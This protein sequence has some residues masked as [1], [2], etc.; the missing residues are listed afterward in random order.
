MPALAAAARSSQSPLKNARSP[1]A[2]PTL[3]PLMFL[4]MW[5][6]ASLTL[7]KPCLTASAIAALCS[8]REVL[9]F[10]F[11]ARADADA[12]EL[13]AQRLLLGDL[14]RELQQEV[15]I[16]DEIG[17]ERV[18]ADE[19]R[20][21]DGRRRRR[22]RLV[23]ERRKRLDLVPGLDLLDV[24]DVLGVE[25]LGAVDDEAELRLGA[26]HLGDPGRLVA[27]PARSRDHVAA[28]A[29]A[30]RTAADVPVVERVHVG[31]HDGVIAASCRSR[32]RIARWAPPAGRPAP[33]STGCR[34]SA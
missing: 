15:E 2:A 17:L 18:L 4:P 28:G 23:Q 13:R 20:E 31:Q 30:R 34:N 10:E 25:E 19:F 9:E 16:G 22:R 27:A 6:A 11:L 8:T 12:R 29:V 3:Q 7:S 32:A 1:C 33:S 14:R 24:V 5:S 21:G 26:E